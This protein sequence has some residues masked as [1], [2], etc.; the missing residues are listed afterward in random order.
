MTSKKGRDRLP[1]RLGNVACASRR[2]LSRGGLR[3]AAAAACLTLLVQ[4]G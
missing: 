3:G 4:V 1:A 2:S